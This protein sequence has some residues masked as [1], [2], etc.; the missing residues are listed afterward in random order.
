[1]NKILTRFFPEI[2]R[3]Q[4]QNKKLVSENIQLKSE[5]SLKQEQINKTNEFWKRKYYKLEKSLRK[6]AAYTHKK[7]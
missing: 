4:Q 1:M 2:E 6:P 5:L 3:I 7:N